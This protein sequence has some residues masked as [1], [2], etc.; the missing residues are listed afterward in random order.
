MR[1]V[2][3]LLVDKEACV[4]SWKPSSPS[5]YSLVHHHD[6]HNDND[7]HDRHHQ[8]KMYIY[9]DPPEPPPKQKKKDLCF[10][11]NFCWPF[12]LKNNSLKNHPRHVNP[13]PEDTPNRHR[14]LERFARRWGAHVGHWQFLFLGEVD[15]DLHREILT[16]R[17]R[18]QKKMSIWVSLLKTNDTLKMMVWNRKFLPTMEIFGVHVSFWECY[19]KG[20]C[21]WDIGLQSK[22]VKMEISGQFW[23]AQNGKE[24]AESVFFWKSII[25]WSFQCENSGGVGCLPLWKVTSLSKKSGTKCVF[26]NFQPSRFQGRCR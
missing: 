1:A 13:R 14:I 16:F 5:S 18:C 26:P 7:H 3:G 20:F 12:F 19:G 23:T 22:M 17:F 8:V 6:H 25:F 24:C 11:R 2:W 9:K 21:C 15:V 10:Q 4:C